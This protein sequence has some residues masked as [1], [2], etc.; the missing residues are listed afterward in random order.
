MQPVAERMC[1][2]ES[3]KDGTL[4]LEDI[5]RMNDCIAVRGD[6]DAIARRVMEQHNG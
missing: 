2:Y 6:N 5:Q 4:D 3:L 1:L